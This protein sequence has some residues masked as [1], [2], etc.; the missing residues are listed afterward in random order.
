WP[1]ADSEHT[2]RRRCSDQAS[3]GA[4]RTSRPASPSSLPSSTFRA[5]TTPGRGFPCSA[6]KSLAVS[7]L[8]CCCCYFRMRLS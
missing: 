4:A 7:S 2:Q 5:K 3:P 6:S 1:R 8:P